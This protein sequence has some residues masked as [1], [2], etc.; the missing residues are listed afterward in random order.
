MRLAWSSFL[1]HWFEWSV[2][3]SGGHYSLA[4]HAPRGPHGRPIGSAGPLYHQPLT[5]LQPH[6]IHSSNISFDPHCFPDTLTP[7]PNKIKKQPLIESDED[8]TCFAGDWI[9]CCILSP[10]TG[11]L[12]RVHTLHKVSIMWQ[13]PSL[14]RDKLFTWKQFA[15]P[16]S[17]FKGFGRRCFY[18]AGSNSPPT[19]AGRAIFIWSKIKPT[20]QFATILGLTHL[21]YTCLPYLYLRFVPSGDDWLLQCSHP[22]FASRFHSGNFTHFAHPPPQKHVKGG[23]STVLYIYLIVD[24]FGLDGKCKI[25]KI[26]QNCLNWL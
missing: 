9:E 7:P 19:S 15:W 25:V 23:S 24:G 3:G 16:Q 1:P 8:I 17:K 21:M 12:A 22:G 11:A 26:V 18:L 20:L 10:M 2:D 5:Y 6:Y 14:H 4:P 13:P